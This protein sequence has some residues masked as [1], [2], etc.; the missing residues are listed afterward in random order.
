[1]ASRLKLHELLKEVIGSNNVYF[2]PP[3]A[4]KLKFP[5]LVYEIRVIDTKY[6]NNRPY[7]HNVVYQLTYIDRDP[8]SPIVMKLADLPQTSWERVYK[9][10]EMYHNVLRITY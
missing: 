4:I 10:N 2:Q 7:Q 8:D 5:C 3:P 1:M 9:A 6:A